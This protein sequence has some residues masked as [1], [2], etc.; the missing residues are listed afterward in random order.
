[1]PKLKLTK[2]GVEALL[3]GPKDI[4]LWDTEL[5]GFGCKITPIGNRFYFCYYR[6]RAGSQ[7][8]PTIGRHGPV[9]A[10]QARDIARRWLAQVAAGGDPS[11]TRQSARNAPTMSAL[12]QRF[13]AEHSE[14][15]NKP[16][17]LYNYQR[18]MDRFIIPALGSRKAADVTRADFQRLHHSLRGT[19][20]QAN[21]VLGL[22]SKMMNLAEKW[23]IRPDGTNP[24]RHV[25]KYREKKRERYLSS[26]ELIR[27]TGALADVERIGTESAAVIAAIKL[28]IFTGSRLSEI[29]TLRWD[30]VNLQRKCLELPDS[31]TG[32]KFVHLNDPA[33]EVLNSL[34]RRDG[35]SHVI[36]GTKLGAHLVNLEKP[37]RRI[38]TR[39]GLEDV[40]LHDLRHTYA[41]IAAGLGEGLPIIGKLLGHTQPATTARYAH[42]A[43]DPLKAANERVGSALAGIMNSSEGGEIAELPQRQKHG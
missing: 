41:S 10:E 1:M 34:E 43:A 3:P 12:C 22:L 8:R 39:A 30:W 36:P 6:T 16:G 23:G 11:Q 42:L 14:V 37:W 18:I 17:T 13:L 40:R 26:D 29:L 38:R 28:L 32:A 24:M 20:Y 7:R 25:E 27:L 4:I 33:V 2:R 35:N 21:R 31:K 9:T 19:P 15:R 5:K